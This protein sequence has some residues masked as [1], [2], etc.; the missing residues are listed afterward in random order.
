MKNQNKQTCTTV[1]VNQYDKTKRCSNIIDWN[2]FNLFTI[3]RMSG[4]ELYLYKNRNKHKACISPTVCWSTRLVFGV[5]F[6]ASKVR[7]SLGGIFLRHVFG[8]NA[9]WSQTWGDYL[10][11]RLRHLLVYQKKMYF[12]KIEKRK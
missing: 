6:I 12:T 11:R 10:G 5:S 1:I 4:T 9:D 7:F 3:P 8:I 2:N